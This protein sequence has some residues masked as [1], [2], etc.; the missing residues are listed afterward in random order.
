MGTLVL[1]IVSLVCGMVAQRGIHLACSIIHTQNRGYD[2]LKDMCIKGVWVVLIM[3]GHYQVKGAL[4]VETQVGG[5]SRLFLGA[6]SV[7]RDERRK[8]AMN[9]T[10]SRING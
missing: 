4:G 10:N 7:L 8:S 6:G 3:L 5:C 9:E 1:S 2:V